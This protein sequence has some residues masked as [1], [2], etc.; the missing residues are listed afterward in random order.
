MPTEDNREG[1][2]YP[3]FLKPEKFDV[4]GLQAL[5]GAAAAAISAVRAYQPFEH[6]PPESH[7]L[8]LLEALSNYDKH[9]LL[10]VI[11]G[12]VDEFWVRNESSGPVFVHRSAKRLL[13][14]GDV[15]ATIKSV[16]PA[17]MP[18]PVRLQVG[19]V[20]ARDGT[21]IG[22]LLDSQFAAVDEVVARVTPFRTVK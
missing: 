16:L 2:S 3:I 9:R 13:V 7:P 4:A 21:P 10:H 8:A 6:Q 19:L 14:N 1:T 11:A 17:A 18:L 15:I 20:L 5:A 22:P 12:V